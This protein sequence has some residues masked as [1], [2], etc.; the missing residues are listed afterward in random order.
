M[1]MKDD[2]DP[3]VIIENLHWCLN[4]VYIFPHFV[5]VVVVF[6]II[7][8]QVEYTLKVMRYVLEDYNFDEHLI[9]HL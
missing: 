2:V 6:W 8:S 1:A 5:Y 7:K 9:E 4:H 3:N